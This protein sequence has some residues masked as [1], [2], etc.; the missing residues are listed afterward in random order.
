MDL[1]AFGGGIAI[2]VEAVVDVTDAHRND[3]DGASSEHDR[4]S[5][6]KKWRSSFHNHQQQQHSPES[7]HPPPRS[8]PSQQGAAKAKRRN[9]AIM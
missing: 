8:P 6:H 3:A 2:P 9:S 5:L 7:T 1:E 4:M